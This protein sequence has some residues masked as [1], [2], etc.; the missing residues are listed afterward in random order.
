MSAFDKLVGSV[1][2]QKNREKRT[3]R[4]AVA[5]ADHEDTLRSLKRVSEAG[6]AEAILIGNRNAILRIADSIGYHIDDSAIIDESDH[7]QA[8]RKA[9]DTVVNGQAD[10]LMKGLVHTSVFSR[11]FLN[12]SAGLVPPGGLISHVGLFEV[13]FYHKPL[14]ITDSAVNIQPDIDKKRTILRNA[15]LTMKRL[16]VNRPK[17]AVIGPVETVNPKIQSTVD[18]ATL[19]QE[20]RTAE[21]SEDCI[22]DGPLAIDG[23]LSKRAARIK[24][25]V[26]DVAGD[27]DLLLCPNLDTANAVNKL[28]NLSSG[29]RSAGIVAGLKI[30]VVLTARSDSDETRFNS[31]CLAISMMP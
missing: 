25:I 29:S 26:S 21:L 17:V 20:Y 14:F 24:G 2:E 12:K 30:P 7:E 3:C 22:L 27:A 1:K 11:A 28:L 8:C 23:A 13:A 15:L 16:G 9:V 10:I 4:I 31:L 19:V 18:A 6:L 5:A